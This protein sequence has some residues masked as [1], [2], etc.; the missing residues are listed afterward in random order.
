MGCGDSLFPIVSRMNDLW[1]D[2]SDIQLLCQTCLHQES[3]HSL[4]FSD[5]HSILYTQ[6]ILHLRT[7]RNSLFKIIAQIKHF[8]RFRE[9]YTDSR[10]PSPR[11]HNK[12]L[13]IMCLPGNGCWEEAVT[14][15]PPAPSQSPWLAPI[16][17][18]VE[19]TYWCLKNSHSSLLPVCTMPTETPTHHSCRLQASKSPNRTLTHPLHLYLIQKRI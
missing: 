1:L 12:S 7:K 18:P 6:D 13:F 8:V 19:S 11:S 15:V 2:L 16:Q 10:P 17:S 14:C 9:L 4:E 3:L 5:M